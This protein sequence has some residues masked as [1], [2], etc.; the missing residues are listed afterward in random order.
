VRGIRRR[1]CQALECGEC[2]LVCAC[3]GV[4]CGCGER[5]ELG[6]AVISFETATILIAIRLAL[7]EGVILIVPSD[8]NGI[9][10]AFGTSDGVGSALEDHFLG[11]TTNAVPGEEDLDTVTCL[12]RIAVANECVPSVNR[13]GLC[14]FNSHDEK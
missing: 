4:G 12:E 6:Q 3:C 1:L 11:V 9:D 7:L 13:D 10:F 2:I 14:N 8:K 5:G